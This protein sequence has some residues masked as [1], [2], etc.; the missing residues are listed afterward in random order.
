MAPYTSAPHFQPAE[1]FHVRPINY[2][3]PVPYHLAQVNVALLRDRLDSPALRE[4]TTRIAEINALAETSPGFVW[5]FRSPE[6]LAYLEPLRGYF[7]PFEP[8]RIFFNLSLW[9][10]LDALRHYAYETPHVELFRRRH[11]WMVPMTKP[12]L[13]CW[14][15]LKGELPTVAEASHRLDL[16]RAHGPIQEAFGFQSCFVPPS[17]RL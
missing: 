11:E 10:S 5:R 16:L 9:A 14:W 3:W 1:S 15:I 12:A 6:G 13:A 17:S 2:A 8:E 4:M 7:E